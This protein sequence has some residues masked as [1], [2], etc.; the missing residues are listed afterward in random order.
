ML[1][2]LER[3][4]VLRGPQGTLFGKNAQGGAVRLVSRAPAANLACARRSMLA[5]TI[6][7]GVA[8]IDL[9]AMGPLTSK[10]DLVGTDNAGW[11]EN[12]APGQEDFGRTKSSGA[13]LTLRWQVLDNVVVDYS[14]DYTDLRS[15]EI[16][17]QLLES[18]DPYT[19]A[20]WPLQ[21][22]RIDRLATACI[23]RS[24]CSAI[25]VIA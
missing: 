16:F 17:N 25:G 21:P 19:A 12:P 13:K 6:P 8:H 24:M 20:A 11:Q 10:I 4:E 14:G 23:V 18:N 2:D 9:P 15:S 3:I 22:E 1:N 7:A 5:I